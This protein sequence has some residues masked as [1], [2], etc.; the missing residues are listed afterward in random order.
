MTASEKIF[1]KDS[2]SN[3]DK[4]LVEMAKVV[5]K[6]LGPDYDVDSAKKII[7]EGPLTYESDDPRRE[8]QKFVGQQYYEITFCPNESS[9]PEYS[10]I[11][12]VCLWTDGTPQHVIFSEGYGFNFFF[13]SFEDLKNSNRI[14][15]RK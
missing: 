11:S 10:Y 15:K 1:S 8:I 9:C 12:K 5:S 4:Q 13:Q 3:Y 2:A 14:L 6:T 7:I